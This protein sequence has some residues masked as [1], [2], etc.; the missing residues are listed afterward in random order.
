MP[1]KMIDLI[2]FYHV[3]GAAISR[4]ETILTLNEFSINLSVDFVLYILIIISRNVRIYFHAF[5]LYDF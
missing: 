3:Q 2:G 1:Q 5:S 4:T